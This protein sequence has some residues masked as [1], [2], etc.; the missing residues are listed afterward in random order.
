[1]QKKHMKDRYLFLDI[2]GVLNTLDYA[3]ACQWK[4]GKVRDEYGALFDPYTVENLR[5][6]LDSTNVRLVVSSSW[7]KNGVEWM[8]ILW[9]ERNLPGEIYGLTPVISKVKFT[10]IEDGTSSSTDLPYA[11]RGL[12]IREWLRK[13][14]EKDGVSYE[15][16][17]ID[18]EDDFLIEQSEH[19]V[20]T[21]AETGLTREVADRVLKVFGSTP[22]TKSTN[23]PAQRYRDNIIL[24]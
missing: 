1:M 16:A 10:N 4:D 9:R 7:R 23:N 15:Y 18:D 5:Y 19:L 14:P 20:I 12:E 8:K 24:S 6:I 21:E 11:K 2:D 17:I 3:K 22:D 13:H